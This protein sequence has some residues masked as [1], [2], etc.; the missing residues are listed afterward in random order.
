MDRYLQAYI[1]SLSTK[2]LEDFLEQY[3]N[4]EFSEDFTY[5]IPYIE[6]VLAHRKEGIQK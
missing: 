3:Y 4:E 5:A 6:Y 1:E 2:Q